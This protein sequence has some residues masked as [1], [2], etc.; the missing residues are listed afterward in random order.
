MS[1]FTPDT[2][3]Y[4]KIKTKSKVSIELLIKKSNKK[5]K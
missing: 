1:R 3:L 5:S 4:F 2:L